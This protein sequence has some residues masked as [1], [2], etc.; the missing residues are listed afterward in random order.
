MSG[1]EQIFNKLNRGP[2]KGKIKLDGNYIELIGEEPHTVVQYR[3][4]CYDIDWAGWCD[5]LRIKYSAVWDLNKSAKLNL[6]RFRIRTHE[7]VLDIIIA[8]TL[9]SEV[10]L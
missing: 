3:R 1:L 10:E 4:N 5:Y 8:G 2:L 9:R 6:S 7:E